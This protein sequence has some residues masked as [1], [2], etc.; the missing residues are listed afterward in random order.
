MIW[1]FDLGSGTQQFQINMRP[2][3]RRCCN[4]R[5]GLGVQKL[6]ERPRHA[7]EADSGNFGTNRKYNNIL[8]IITKEAES[9]AETRSISQATNIRTCE[10]GLNCLT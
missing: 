3:A 10:E 1:R 9:D 8:T 4:V 6:L 2:P 7:W 5:Q